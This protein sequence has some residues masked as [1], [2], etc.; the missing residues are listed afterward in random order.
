M[1]ICPRQSFQPG[2]QHGEPTDACLLV[3]GIKDFREFALIPCLGV[4]YDKHLQ[5]EPSSYVVMRG[6]CLTWV[7]VLCWF[8]QVISLISFISEAMRLQPVLVVATL[9]MRLAP[10]RNDL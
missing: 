3:G 8:D 5:Y 4:I 1:S 6:V 10:H 7:I 2:S 9:Y